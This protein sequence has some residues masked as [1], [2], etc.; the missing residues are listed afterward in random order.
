MRRTFRFPGIDEDY[1]VTDE[2]QPF[3]GAAG[4]SVCSRRTKPID[5][6]GPVAKI[7]SVAVNVLSRNLP[8][9]AAARTALAR[10]LARS[11]GPDLAAGLDRFEVR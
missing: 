7:L 11:P 1:W 6:P 8:D 4:W 5:T 9:E 3:P 10:H 2:P